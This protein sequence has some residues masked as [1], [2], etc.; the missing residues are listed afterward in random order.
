MASKIGDEGMVLPNAPKLMFQDALKLGGSLADHI[1]TLIRTSF[2]INGELSHTQLQDAGEEQTSLVDE[3]QEVMVKNKLVNATD[4]K[5][6]IDKNLPLPYLAAIKNF[7]DALPA[8]PT[9][10]FLPN[11]QEYPHLIDSYNQWEQ[12]QLTCLEEMVSAFSSTTESGEMTNDRYVEMH[13]AIAAAMVYRQSMKPDSYLKP[14]QSRWNSEEARFS[15]YEEAL[16]AIRD[17]DADIN[18]FR[19][20]TKSTANRLFSRINEHDMEIADRFHKDFYSAQKRDALAGNV[21]SFKASAPSSFSSRSIMNR[22]Y[23]IH[24]KME[25]CLVDLKGGG[26]SVLDDYVLSG[27]LKNRGGGRYRSFSIVDHM[28]SRFEDDRPELILKPMIAKEFMGLTLNT[29]T[30]AAD[31]ANEQE[32]SEHKDLP[33][34]TPVDG[35]NIPLEQP[36]RPIRLDLSSEIASLEDLDMDD[37]EAATYEDFR[38]LVDHY[39]FRGLQI[40]NYVPQK[41][42]RYLTNAIHQSVTD[43][44]SALQVP[45]TFVA[46]GNPLPEELKSEGDIE[47]QS[48][49]GMSMGLALGARGRGKASAHYEPGGSEKNNTKRHII[50]L[51]RDKGAGSFSHEVGHGLDY[52]LAELCD[53]DDIASGYADKMVSRVTGRQPGRGIATVSEAWALYWTL[54]VNRLQQRKTPLPSADAVRQAAT[55]F[56]KPEHRTAENI[57]MVLGIGGVMKEIYAKEL[58]PKELLFRHGINYARNALSFLKNTEDDLIEIACSLYDA[59]PENAKVTLASKLFWTEEKRSTYNWMEG[60]SRV[61]FLQAE[62]LASEFADHAMEQIK[63]VNNR[64]PAEETRLSFKNALSARIQA[65]TATADAFIAAMDNDQLWPSDE[66]DEGLKASFPNG[67]KSL[68]TPEEARKGFDVFV[69]SMATWL[70]TAENRERMRSLT[71]A[72]ESTMFA[73]G[74]T[75]DELIKELQ[76]PTPHD[77]EKTLSQQ[78][79]AILLTKLAAYELNQKG[80]HAFHYAPLTDE[81]NTKDLTAYLE[82]V[83]ALVD[84]MAQDGMEMPQTYIDLHPRLLSRVGQCLE[85]RFDAFCVTLFERAEKMLALADIKDPVKERDYPH[86]PSKG[87]LKSLLDKESLEAIKDTVRCLDDN[88]ESPERLFDTGRQFSSYLTLINVLQPLVASA[89]SQDEP[90]MRYADLTEKVGAEL[91]ETF[92]AIGYAVRSS[93]SQEKEPSPEVREKKEIL[94]GFFEDFALTNKAIFSNQDMVLPL[95]QSIDH[96]DAEAD[97][98]A[99]RE[100][101]NAIQASLRDTQ[102][103][104]IAKP[105]RSATH[106]ASVKVI[107][108]GDGANRFISDWVHNAVR[109]QP[110]YQKNVGINGTCEEYGVALKDFCTQL[111]ASKVR[112]PYMTP[113]ERKEVLGEIMGGDEAI[114]SK[115]DILNVYKNQFSVEADTQHGY[116]PVSQWFKQKI[117]LASCL[118]HRSSFD[119][120]DRKVLN[121]LQSRYQ[122]YL[123][124]DI[125]PAESSRMLR[126]SAIYEDRLV[127]L[128]AYPQGTRFKYWPTPVETFARSFETFVNDTL[129]DEGIE[130]RYLVTVASRDRQDAQLKSLERLVATKCLESPM[131]FYSNNFESDLFYKYKGDYSLN[132]PAGEERIRN[133]EACTKLARSLEAGLSA[134]FPEAKALHERNIKEGVYEQTKAKVSLVSA[135]SRL[136]EALGDALVAGEALLEPSQSSP[137][138]HD[139][140]Q[141]PDIAVEPDVALGPSSDELTTLSNPEHEIVEQEPALDASAERDGAENTGAASEAT[142]PQNSYV[143]EDLKVP[144]ALRE[145]MNDM[146]EEAGNQD[147]EDGQKP[148]AESPCEPKEEPAEVAKRPSAPKVRPHT[149]SFDF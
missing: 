17:E 59:T 35:N 16:R 73:L 103:L 101:I 41:T 98:D 137:E 127:G 107:E 108:A 120:D 110:S 76:S 85:N 142:E 129:E 140:Y 138:A 60:I 22:V 52:T 135:S 61:G 5:E 20:V 90:A 72:A 48:Y 130:S 4:F 70:V 2:N 115:D 23:K 13:L 27:V 149:P 19:G 124:P 93:Y 136:P 133:Q 26:S 66:V 146:L 14:G 88:D 83:T 123:H 147:Y 32:A 25:D 40:G 79:A 116:P 99:R 8:R 126:A 84:H 117:A 34:G 1:D 21:W 139:S 30:P 113:D 125:T 141:Q 55:T 29:A 105:F 38:Y 54:A 82:A 28:A 11:I 68:Q 24:S 69:L 96:N 64:A 51:T 144:A 3:W 36:R 112:F 74:Y 95:W 57:D 100:F 118:I 49:S 63:T 87:A 81:R 18:Y 77:M 86:I 53:L 106:E 94:E 65:A 39:G 12:Q 71:G 62:L 97:I 89:S 37:S 109:A 78:P 104:L 92:Q 91:R 67:L 47:H 58:D 128:N 45:P 121:H 122:K 46:L 50:N 6:L 15:S 31:K 132:Y 134:R 43:L 148:K 44:A 42:R 80:D 7:R 10:A 111:T 143:N 9:T 119:V 75:T 56:L 131:S 102:E 33:E 114:P 145:G